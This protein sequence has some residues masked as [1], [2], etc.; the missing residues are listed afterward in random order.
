[1]PSKSRPNT[2][3][4]GSWKVAGVRDADEGIGGRQRTEVEEVEE[5][6]VLIAEQSPDAAVAD[7]ARH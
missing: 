5:R 3:K 2:S 7:H 4:G 6:V 1:M